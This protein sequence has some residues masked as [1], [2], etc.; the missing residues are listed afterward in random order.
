MTV[1]KLIRS[2]ASFKIVQWVGRVYEE[3]LVCR[4]IERT[5]A[6]V[7]S[8]WESSL[9][10][11]LVL[12]GT[13]RQHRAA[14]ASLAVTG[15]L[16]LADAAS[17]LMRPPAARLRRYG[18]ESLLYRSLTAPVSP[19]DAARAFIIIVCLLQALAYLLP[20]LM[21]SP[22]KWAA[23]IASSLLGWLWPHLARILPTSIAVQTARQIWFD[24]EPPEHTGRTST[25]PGRRLG[26]TLM[27]A[28]AGLLFFLLPIKW[29]LLIIAGGVLLLL[30]LRE[31]ALGLYGAAFVTP[32]LP[33]YLMAMLIMGTFSIAVLRALWY[34]QAP[35]R[36]IP[37]DLLLLLLTI[38][39]FIATVT[40]ILP[41][42]SLVAFAVFL[43]GV[44]LSYLIASLVRQ[45]LALK[46]L[47]ITLVS[48]SLIVSLYG[49]FQYFV[50]APVNLGWVDVTQN[51]N[52][53]VRAFSTLENPNN[54]A[55]YLLMVIPI[56]GV[57]V[58]A[59]RS[60]WNRALGFAGAVFGILTLFLT[61]SRGGWV[62]FAVGALLFVLLVNWRLILLGVG[63]LPL[64]PAVLP[65]TILDRLLT[66][67]GG[68]T[69]V[70][71]RADIWQAAIRMFQAN[72]WGI[73]FGSDLFYE[74]Y[75]FYRGW[76]PKAFHAHN[77][78]LEIGVEIGVVGLLVV[79]WFFFRLAQEGLRFLRRAGGCSTLYTRLSVAAALAGFGGLL[80]HGVGEYVWFY[81]KVLLTFWLIVGMLLACIS[82]AQE[83]DLT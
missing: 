13:A 23:G 21:L 29:F 2:S 68:D 16:H 4:L 67:G 81:P 56:A 6:G 8:A 51:P 30:L 34:G 66:L 40:S 79:L 72:P 45:P 32:F 11:D 41:R 10:N 26:S 83:Q 53:T 20:A 33:F 44:A 69:S 46:R 31:P 38:V 43:T 14:S 80:V 73:G 61:Y 5:A 59:F 82:F 54:L 60:F 37:L 9:F 71:Y 22:Q 50:I 78:F 39:W 25:A 70:S 57:L 24:A 75:P 28:L 15:T 49:L 76:A 48:S 36:R 58:A 7:S 27:G 1:D 12:R 47:M 52:I 18:Q 77:L 62:G 63:L 74:L 17:S 3:S 42:R 64:L 55:E 19:P 35:L 65:Q